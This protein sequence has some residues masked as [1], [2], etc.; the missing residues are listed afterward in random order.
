MDEIALTGVDLALVLAYLVGVTGLGLWLSRGIKSSRD[1]FLAGKT[2]PWWAVGMSLVVSDIGAKDMVGLTADGYRY[3]LVMMNFDLIG[4]V[5][6]VLV[7]AF[8]FM[9]FLWMAGVYTL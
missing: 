5:F 9:P 6:P 2:L 1:F 4:C 7:A 8:L 3:G